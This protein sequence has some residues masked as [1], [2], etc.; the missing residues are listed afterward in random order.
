MDYTVLENDFNCACDEVIVNLTEQYKLNYQ[1]GGPGKLEAF[2]ELIRQEFEKVV[3][4]FVS[5][6]DLEKDLQG[7]SLIQNIAKKYAKS[8]LDKYSKIV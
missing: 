7:M 5:K 6:N 1:S 3:A 2:L 8:C 4:A